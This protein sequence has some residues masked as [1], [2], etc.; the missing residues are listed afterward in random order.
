MG[1]LSSAMEG[2]ESVLVEREEDSGASGLVERGLGGVTMLLAAR[3]GGKFCREVFVV[4]VVVVCCCCCVDVLNAEEIP[5]G[6]L[7]GRCASCVCRA[8]GY[9]LWTGMEAG[10]G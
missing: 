10:A 8:E 4:V 2:V 9:V 6:W 5:A 7:C 1:S 3:G